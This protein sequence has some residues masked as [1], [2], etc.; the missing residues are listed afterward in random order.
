M[1]ESVPQQTT[2]EGFLAVDIRVGRVV[3]AE[4]FEKARRPAYKL[5]V[6]FGPE[7]GVRKSSAQVTDLYT[8]EDLKDRQVMAVVNLPPRQIADFMSEV[9]VL[10]VPGERGGDVALIAPD[11]DVTPGL[12]LL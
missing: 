11:R 12:R 5:W 8:V 7:L 2:I 1:T 9:L 3:R 4:P 10:G 6:D